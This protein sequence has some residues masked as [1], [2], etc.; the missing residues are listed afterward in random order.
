V[1][2]NECF[3]NASPE[4]VFA[5]LADPYSYQ[6]WVVGAKEVRQADEEWPAPGSKLHHSIG[7][8]PFTLKDNTKVVSADPPRHLVLRARG[9][10]LGAAI[11]EFTLIPEGSGTR[12]HLREWIV[13]PRL[14][15]VLNPLFEPGVRL[16]NTKTLQRLS[17][18]VLA[19][20]PAEADT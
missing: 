12:L 18:V 6:R 9:R 17:D 16:R 14:L 20:N 11:V 4:S 2:L 15:A 7:F 19:T 3:I 5:V 8:G 10:P 13:E 1:A